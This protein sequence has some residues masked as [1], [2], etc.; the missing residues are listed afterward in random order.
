MKYFITAPDD[1]VKIDKKC[2]ANF[3]HLTGGLAEPLTK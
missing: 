1:E 2:G 3:I